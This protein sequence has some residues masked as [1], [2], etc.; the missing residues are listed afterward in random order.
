MTKLIIRIQGTRFYGVNNHH[1]KLAGFSM[2]T[3]RLR[4]KYSC[5]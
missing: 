1:P 4:P 5:V 2:K 3:D